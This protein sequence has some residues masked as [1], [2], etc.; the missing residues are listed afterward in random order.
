M[1]IRGVPCGGTII[2]GKSPTLDSEQLSV[3]IAINL[4]VSHPAG[5]YCWS[6]RKRYIGQYEEKLDSGG[7][8]VTDNGY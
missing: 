5:S 3:I 7:S 6:V 4:G 2:V 1:I 8:H